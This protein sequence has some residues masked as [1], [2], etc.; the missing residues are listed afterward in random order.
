MKTFSLTAR[1]IIAV[2]VCQLVLAVGVPV[3]TVFYVRGQ[4]RDTIDTALQGRAMSTLAAV[5][6]SETEPPGLLF[7]AALVPPSSD[8]TYPDFYEVVSSDGQVLAK[9]PGLQSV[10]ADVTGS[11]DQFT[12]FMYGPVEYR[13]VALRG[14]P[15]LDDE[16]TVKVPYR[17]TVYYGSSLVDHHNRLIALAVFVATVSFLLLATASL[18]ATWAIRRGLMPLRQLALQ[19][20]AI[21][22]HNWNF[23]PPS[24]AAL[25]TELAPL[26]TAIEGLIDRLKTAFRQQRDFT[27]D[28]AHELKTSAAIVKST[29]QSLLQKPRTTEEYRAGLERLLDDSNRL[30]D[31]L[32][33]ML[34]L[35]RIEQSMDNGSKR[36]YA[37]TELTSTCEIAVSRI[38]ALAQPRDVVIEMDG[39]KTLPLRADPEDLELIWV[40]LLENAVYYSP[41]GAKV[42]LNIYADGPD[43]VTVSVRDSGPG[44]PPDDVAKIFERFHRADPSRAR[45]SGGFGLGLS[46]CKAIVDAYG[47]KI[48][49]SNRSSGGAEISVELPLSQGATESSS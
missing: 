28:A 8:R 20:G 15:V 40:N 41:R 42:S 2:V 24:D 26:V 35:A 49:A 29:A 21:S 7:D 37:L 45:S 39:D 1:I 34:R 5:R 36:H 27:S 31:L 30:E 25:A 14:V 48:Y 9:S 32:N 18:L 38:R 17:V 12:S 22:V 13:G 3:A 10:P 43:V 4:Y 11:T 44:I 6:Y 47:G 19:A 33:R 23:D 46:I 16:D